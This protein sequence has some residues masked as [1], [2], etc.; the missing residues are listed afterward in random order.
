MSVDGLVLTR[1]GVLVFVR[2]VPSRLLVKGK[3]SA[4]NR[5][6][7]G[8]HQPFCRLGSRELTSLFFL[9]GV[10]NPNVG[11]VGLD[12]RVRPLP[13]FITPS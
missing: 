12:V 1:H 2:G 9:D 3:E 4:V 10:V 13:V 8:I 7:Y 5:H 11:L 6:I